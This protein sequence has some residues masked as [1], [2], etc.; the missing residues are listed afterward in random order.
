MLPKI[1]SKFKPR[2]RA[3]FSPNSSL[4]V[5]QEI[6]RTKPLEKCLYLKKME[7]IYIFIYTRHL[8]HDKPFIALTSRENHLT[9]LLTSYHD[10]KHIGKCYGRNTQCYKN[11]E[12]KETSER[13]WIWS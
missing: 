10:A 3:D 13:I 9:C 5:S 12:Q 11:S 6:M 1:K 7:N 4:G 8:K 2:K